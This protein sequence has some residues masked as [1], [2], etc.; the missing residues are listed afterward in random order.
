MSGNETDHCVID[1][2]SP[3]AWKSALRTQVYTVTCRIEN[4]KDDPIG[5]VSRVDDFDVKDPDTG[6]K[7]SHR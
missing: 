1:A 4:W 7:S 6:R 2:I 5:E 3:F